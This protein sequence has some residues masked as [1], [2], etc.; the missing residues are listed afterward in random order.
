MGKAFFKE[1]QEVEPNGGNLRASKRSYSGIKHQFGV[2]IPRNVAEAYKLGQPNGTSLCTEAIDREVNCFL[3]IS[4]IFELAMNL[5]S[6]TITRRF[7]YCGPLQ[8]SLMRVTEP[9]FALE[10]I[11]HGILRRI[12]TTE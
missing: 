6:L 2:R 5:K 8:S 9:N 4:N 1:Y 10:G 7:L 11:G 3:A 12:I